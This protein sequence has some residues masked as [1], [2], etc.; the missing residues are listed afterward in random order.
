MDRQPNRRTTSDEVDADEVMIHP[1]RHVVE[2]VAFSPRRMN[3]LISDLCPLPSA[4]CLSPLAGLEMMRNRIPTDESV[5]YFRMSLRDRA[6]GC[7]MLEVCPAE[8]SAQAAR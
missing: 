3:D 2:G 7:V 8:N 1:K 6:S 5:G 4:L